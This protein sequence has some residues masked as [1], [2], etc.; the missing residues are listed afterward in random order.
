M[1]PLMRSRNPGAIITGAPLRVTV[2]LVAAVL[3]SSRRLPLM[4]IPSDAPT[5]LSAATTKAPSTPWLSMRSEP[6]AL[7]VPRG[8][9]FTEA[10][11]SVV[12]PV[13]ESENE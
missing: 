5:P 6:L 9:S 1:L 2:R 3:I 12:M 10:D 7:P 4:V 13:E 11:T 8:P